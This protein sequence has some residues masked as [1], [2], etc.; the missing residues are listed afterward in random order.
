MNK[1]LVDAFNKQINM[2][3]SSA[4]YY[5]ALSTAMDE[6]KYSGYASWLKHQFDEEVSHAQKMIQYLQDNDQK[7]EF[8]TIQCKTETESSPLKV[9]KAVYAHELLVTK[10]IHELYAMAEEAKD[11]RTR[12]FLEWFVAEQ[13]EEEVSTREVVDKFTLADDKIS[14][15]M[16]IDN[17]LGDRQ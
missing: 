8:S 9:A 5:L 17:I 1:E 12:N 10:K 6:N 11:Y 15:N 16:M 4:Y 13:L 7:V 3:W 14:A 2:E